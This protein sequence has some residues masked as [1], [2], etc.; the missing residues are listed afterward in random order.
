MRLGVRIGV[1]TGEVLAPTSAH[2]GGQF[3]VSGDPVNV[4]AR[5]EQAADPATVLV[6]ERTWQAAR[7]AF[8][9]GEPMPLTLKGKREPVVARSL[10]KPIAAEQRGVRFQAPMIGRDRELA[11]AARPAG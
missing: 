11:T 1:N 9:F 5:L 6:G 2:A 4:A 3:I 7:T 10:G 8:E